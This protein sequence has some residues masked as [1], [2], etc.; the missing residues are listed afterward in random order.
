MLHSVQLA[1]SEDDEGTSAYTVELQDFKISPNF[2]K[3]WVDWKNLRMNRAGRN[4]FVVEGQV[5]LNMN[6]ADDQSVSFSKKECPNINI[7]NEYF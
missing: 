6:L 2:D 3:K 5:S 1:R 4:K 7:K